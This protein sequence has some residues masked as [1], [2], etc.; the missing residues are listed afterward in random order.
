MIYYNNS[1][2]L[3][4]HGIKGQKWGVRRFQN[5][6]GSLTSA[7][8]KRYYGVSKKTQNAMDKAL[9]R[10]NERYEAVDDK[11]NKKIS[12]LQKKYGHPGDDASDEEYEKWY[13]N[14]N[15]KVNS[16]AR[17][18]DQAASRL[19]DKSGFDSAYKKDKKD[20]EKAWK[21]I[22]K[23]KELRSI[24]SDTKSLMNKS[25]ELER[26]YVGYNSKAYKDAFNKYKKQ[27]GMSADDDDTSG[28]DEDVWGEWNKD[29]Q[30]AYK[31]YKQASKGIDKQ[32]S[33]SVDNFIKKGFGDEKVN[34]LSKDKL[35]QAR[36]FVDS[37][38]R[39][40]FKN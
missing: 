16:K 37:Q 1:S 30:A 17:K 21:T 33:K 39:H 8:E 40:R 18:Y 15:G 6:D 25:E 35:N 20:E 24:M 11:Y 13:F 29:Y 38:I 34:S 14:K 5:E 27:K 31:Q 19:Y 9:F 2:S 32:I 36:T 4:H 3:T 23:N 22:Q 7:G 10:R 26:Q 28:F 12:K